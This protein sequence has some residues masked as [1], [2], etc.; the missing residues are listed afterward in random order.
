V[1][2]YEGAVEFLEGVV[3]V[4]VDDVDGIPELL[5]DALLVQ[6]LLVILIEP[7]ATL[8]SAGMMKL[9]EPKRDWAEAIAVHV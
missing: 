9:Y 3:E 5:L 4:E 7:L 1:D 8:L 2:D 6:P